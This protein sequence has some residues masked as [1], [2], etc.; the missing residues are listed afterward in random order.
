MK[1]LIAV[2]M[3]LMMS[4]CATVT[5]WGQITDEGNR[6]IAIQTEGMQ[7]VTARTD[8]PEAEAVLAV[9]MEEVR[10]IFTQRRVQND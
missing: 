10:K 5:P 3:A 2:V 4:G 9:I 6:I 1:L 7:I 8:G